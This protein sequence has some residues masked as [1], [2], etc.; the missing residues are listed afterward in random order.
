MSIFKKRGAVSAPE[1]P[2]DDLLGDAEAH[3]F[4]AE[5][6]REIGRAHV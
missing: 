6:E 2:L 3:A 1:P 5:L 4:R